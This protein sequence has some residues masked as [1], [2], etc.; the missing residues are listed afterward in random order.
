MNNTPQGE[1]EEGAMVEEIKKII[2]NE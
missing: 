1:D 2:K